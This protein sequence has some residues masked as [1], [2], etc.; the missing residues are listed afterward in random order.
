MPRIT[1]LVSWGF[2]VQDV[3]IPDSDPKDG[4]LLHNGN[5]AIKTKPGKMVVFIDSQT[6]D[7]IR[8]R[9]SAEAKAKLVEQLSGGILVPP[10]AD[11]HL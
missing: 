7:Q 4:Q 5:G 9:L 6:G 2:A 1:E 10:T 8:I 3:E 11:I